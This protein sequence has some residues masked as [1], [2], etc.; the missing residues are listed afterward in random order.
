[1][2]RKFSR[3]FKLE[4]VKLV[5]GRGVSVAQAC[6]DLDVAESVLRRWM[7]ELAGAPASAFPGQGQLR[8]EQAEI[9]AL[10][11]EVA[12][13]KAERDI[14]KKAAAFFAREST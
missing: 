9:A 6:R 8:A 13:L 2:R 4:A 14:L 11:K 10:K 12:R 1:M 7:R 5:T 3:E